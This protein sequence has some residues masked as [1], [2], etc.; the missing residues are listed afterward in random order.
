MSP[1][2][3]LCW[4][5]IIQNKFQYKTAYQGKR[6]ITTVKAKFLKVLFGWVLFKESLEH[7]KNYLGM[8][9]EDILFSQF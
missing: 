8:I 7:L 3:W 4:L 5:N 1:V 6:Q 2:V 9:I